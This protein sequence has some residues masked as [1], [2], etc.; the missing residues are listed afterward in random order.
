MALVGGMLGLVS[1]FGLIGALS[2]AIRPRWL[3]A[4]FLVSFI[5]GV[6]IVQHWSEL[7]QEGAFDA[8]DLE[9]IAIP[10]TIPHLVSQVWEVRS[11]Q[12]D[13]AALRTPDHRITL[14]HGV[15]WEVTVD[16]DGDEVRRGATIAF[17]SGLP[18]E[19]R[20][21]CWVTPVDRFRWPSGGAVSRDALTNTIERTLR[22]TRTSAAVVV[23]DGY[24]VC[25]CSARSGRSILRFVRTTELILHRLQALD[26]PDQALRDT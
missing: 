25:N 26:Q 6:W 22:D 11:F 19:L 18:A 8:S 13:T 2:G 3:A 1:M 24:L 14:V 4:A 7:E 20:A 23:R 9:R 21:H 15:E 10:S 5:A 12:K 17:A 16:A